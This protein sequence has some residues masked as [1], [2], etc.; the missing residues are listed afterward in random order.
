MNVEYISHEE[1][2][3]KDGDRLATVLVTVEEPGLGKSISLGLKVDSTPWR[4]RGIPVLYT[5]VA[6]IGIA[7]SL[8]MPSRAAWVPH[9]NR[10]DEPGNVVGDEAV[11]QAGPFLKNRRF[12]GTR[13]DLVTEALYQRGQT[14]QRD[15]YQEVINA[16]STVGYD[17]YNLSYPNTWGRGL[18]ASLKTEFRHERIRALSREDEIPSFNDPTDSL[19]FQPLLSWDRRDNPLHPTKG[20]LIL[21]SAELL[22]PS[23]SIGRMCP[24]RPRSL[25]SSYTRSSNGN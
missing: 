10:L 18:R 17:F 20:F 9:S 15:A 2:V 7:T 22:I 21:A 25:R 16:Q 6:L 24:S 12:F 14:G 5:M 1:A 4:G 13:L 23:L 19:A 11:W 8:A 3:T